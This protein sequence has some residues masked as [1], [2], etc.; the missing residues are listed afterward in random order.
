MSC[1][2]FDVSIPALLK[3]KLAELRGLLVLTITQNE[4]SQLICMRF[5]P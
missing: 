3:L 1:K 4:F 2:F 5:E